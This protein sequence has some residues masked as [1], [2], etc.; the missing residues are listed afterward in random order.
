M[1]RVKTGKVIDKK[2]CYHDVPG[3][4][5]TVLSTK[6]ANITMIVWKI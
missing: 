2:L 1:L 6:L 3:T 5:D 4:E